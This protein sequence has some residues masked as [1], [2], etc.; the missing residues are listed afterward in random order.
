MVY[1]WEIIYY[2][3]YSTG[4]CDTID[5]ALD[6]MCLRIEEEFAGN[7]YDAWRDA[8]VREYYEINPSCNFRDQSL[9]VYCR[10]NPNIHV[11]L[12]RWFRHHNRV[13][14]GRDVNINWRQEGF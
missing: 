10:N 14:A 2:P 12:I 5:E 3:G 11:R 9:E 1:R 4:W 7:R 6:W 13:R 8:T